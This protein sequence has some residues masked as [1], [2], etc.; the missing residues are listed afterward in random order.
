[1][2]D[3]DGRP[4]VVQDANDE[5][6][7]SMPWSPDSRFSFKLLL[8]ARLSSALWAIVS[9]CDETY[10]YWEPTHFLLY[11]EGFQVKSAFILNAM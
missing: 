4:Y 3:E 9:D 10:N 8:T 7:S 1:V 2:T 6:P 5:V 11:G